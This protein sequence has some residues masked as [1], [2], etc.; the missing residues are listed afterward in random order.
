MNRISSFLKTFI[1]S[2]IAAPIVIPMGIAAGF[3]NSSS[4]GDGIAFVLGIIG[5]TGL[6]VIS[7]VSG[8]GAL[9]GFSFFKVLLA[10]YLF[11]CALFAYVATAPDKK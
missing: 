9:I 10:L 6:L 2:V 1:I 11:G 8:L 7:G 5:V 3:S 4:F